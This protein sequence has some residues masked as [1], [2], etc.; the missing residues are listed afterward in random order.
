[1]KKLS[2]NTAH[3]VK[4][5]QPLTRLRAHIFTPRHHWDPELHSSLLLSTAGDCGVLNIKHGKHVLFTFYGPL[6]SERNSRALT[7]AVRQECL[8]SQYRGN[9]DSE[10]NTGTLTGGAVRQECLTSQCQRER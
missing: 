10:R 7:G 5:L 1:M 9:A 4:L 8:T 2:T 6:H 3:P